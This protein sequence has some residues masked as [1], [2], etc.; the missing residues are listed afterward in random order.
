MKISTTALSYTFHIPAWS[1]D[2]K[3]VFNDI[4]LT[5][6]KGEWTGI[7]GRS[8]CGK[9]TLLRVMAG[10]MDGHIISPNI[11]YMAQQDG[12]LPWASLLDNVLLPQ[13]FYPN[14]DRERAYRLLSDMGLADIA[15][16]KPHILS[17]GMRQ[18]VALARTLMTT[19]DIILLDE[20]FSALDYMT[21]HEMHLLTQR[22]LTDK[23]VILVTHDPDEAAKLCDYTYLMKNAE[24]TP[25]ALPPEHQHRIDALMGDL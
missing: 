13:K 12:L 1:F 20:P 10:L 2:T 11:T 3:H 16:E 4:N 14:P 6:V 21:R 19:A 23:T 17:Q 25:Y 22:F 7:L 9:S 15:H 24:L 18:R 5:L 8:G